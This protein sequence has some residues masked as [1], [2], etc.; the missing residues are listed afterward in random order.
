MVSLSIWLPPGLDN[1]RHWQEGE[2]EVGIFVSRA[3]FLKV[4][5]DR[6]H[7]SPKDHISVRWSSSLSGSKGGNFILSLV[8]ASSCH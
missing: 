8:I 6:L 7:I 5:R 4:T 3:S 2:G 1:E